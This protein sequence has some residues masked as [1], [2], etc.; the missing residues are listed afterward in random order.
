MTKSINGGK[1]GS[2]SFS[3][4]Q[5][6]TVGRTLFLK[7]EE[8]GW[9]RLAFFH[10]F[11]PGANLGCTGSREI[12]TLNLAES[13]IIGPK[14]REATKVNLGFKMFGK[15]HKNVMTVAAFF[16]SVFTILDR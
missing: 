9:W 13:R 12:K 8:V 1:N 3:Q 10:P 6:T 11:H 2:F 16:R 5:D 15:A 4:G 14:D 7:T